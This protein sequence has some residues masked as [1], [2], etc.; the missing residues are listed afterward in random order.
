MRVTYAVIWKEGDDPERSGRLELT[1]RTLVFKGSNGHGAHV[2]EIDYRDLGNVRVGRA[3]E[4]RIDGRPTVMLALSGGGAVRILS[5]AQPGIIA[6]LAERIVALHVERERTLTRVA[7]IV[8]LVE[9]A[10][11]RARALLASGPPF[12]P[13]AWDLE[14]HHVFATDSEV[15]FVFEANDEGVLERLAG[16]SAFWAARSEW[17][18]IVAGAPHIAPAVYSWS[19]PKDEA[20]GVSFE[21]TPGPGDSEGGDVFAPPG[22]SRVTD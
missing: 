3:A 14:D 13:A 2:T 1:P 16:N 7:V 17:K 18:E 11:D 8:P 6:E 20:T 22:S 4:E 12:D 5:V 21:P 10:G 15:V 9:G 19:R